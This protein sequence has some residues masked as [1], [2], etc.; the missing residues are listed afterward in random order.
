MRKRWFGG[1]SNFIWAAVQTAV[2]AIAV[3]ATPVCASAQA[4]ASYGILAGT[5]AATTAKTATSVN[6]ATSKLAGRIADSVSKSGAKSPSM[7]LSKPLRLVMEENRQKL[8]AKSKDG[9]AT[10]HIQS[11]PDKATVLI[12]GEA[13][14]K[15]PADLKI[16]EGE[17]V[18]ELKEF[19]SLDWKK[20]ISVAR[21]EDLS[22]KPELKKR[23]ASAITVSF[24]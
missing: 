18:V 24:K 15:T 10:L 11:V 20:E 12:D 6:R 13:V 9:G 1:K 21:D 4:A 5:S 14:A 22:L 23:Y 16:P 3:A 17:H 8:E 19:E 7:S 2:V